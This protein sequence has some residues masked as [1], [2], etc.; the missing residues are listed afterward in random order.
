MLKLLNCLKK[1]LNFSY[2]LHLFL[3]RKTPSQSEELTE[4]DSLNFETLAIALN[5]RTSS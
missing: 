5:K 1:I 4:P 3:T 2:F